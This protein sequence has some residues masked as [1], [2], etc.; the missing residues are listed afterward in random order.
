MTEKDAS[1]L[2]EQIR[3][4]ILNKPVSGE[5]EEKT[6]VFSDLEQAV[7]YLSHCLMESNEFLKNLAEGNLD[8]PLPARH[9]F[10]AGELKQLYAALKHLTWQ[11]GQVIKGDYKQR[12]NFMGD[13]SRAFNE[14]VVKLEKRENELKEQAEKIKRFNRLLISIMDSLKEWV[15]VID[16]ENGA[17]LYTNEA[18]RRRFYDPGT[19]QYACGEENCLLMDRIKSYAGLEQEL[20]YEFKCARNKTLQVKSYSLMWEE[21]KAVVHLVTDITYQR[22]NEAFLEVMAYKDE[23]T[24]LDNRRSGLRT[25]DSYIQKGIPFSL[26]MI[27]MDGLKSINDQFGHLLGDEYIKSVSEALKESARDIDFTCRFGGDEFIMLFRDCE[28][29]FAEERMDLID[30]KL[31]DAELN[32]PMSISYGVVYIPKGTALSPEAALNMADERMYRFKRQRKQINN[33]PGGEGI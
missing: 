16:E 29:Q 30:K 2:L 14:M 33:G 23:L 12:V 21:K 28:K 7:F 15:V 27:D 8:V 13:F 11:T 26:C 19:G 1:V 31:S 20:R 5:L 4:I 3:N 18:A 9:N 6:Q 10:Q 17:V 32:Y 24:G 25:I 22:E